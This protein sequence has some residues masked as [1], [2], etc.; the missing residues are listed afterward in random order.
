MVKTE[1]IIKAKHRVIVA[2]KEQYVL[3][4]PEVAYNIHFDS[5]KCTLSLMAL[6]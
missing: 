5:K 3:K 2:E 4:E 6:T 1:L